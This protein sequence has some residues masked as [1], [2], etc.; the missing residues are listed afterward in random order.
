MRCV[1]REVGRF[2]LAHKL[3]E[4]APGDLKRVSFTVGGGPSLEAAMKIGYKNTQPSRDFICL[5]DSIPAYSCPE[6][7]AFKEI[8]ISAYEYR[9]V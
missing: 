8:Q 1:A 3:A 6:R 7:S 5:Y 9:R 4:L 2:Y